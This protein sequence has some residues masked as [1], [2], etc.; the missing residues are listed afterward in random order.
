MVD[1][2]ISV[3][4]LVVG[5]FGRTLAPIALRGLAALAPCVGAAV[6]G[7]VAVKQLRSDP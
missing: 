6:L 2:G 1:A 3:P 4:H 5:G 7:W